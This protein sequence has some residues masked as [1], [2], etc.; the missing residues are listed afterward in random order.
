MRAP[1]FEVPVV[2]GDDFEYFKQRAG[3][4]SERQVLRATIV[5]KASLPVAA[6]EVASVAPP[7]AAPGPAPVEAPAPPKATKRKREPSPP[8]PATPTETPTPVES[9][10]KAK[11]QKNAAKP[12]EARAEVPVTQ[13]STTPQ[14][15][16][17][18]NESLVDAPKRKKSRAEKKQLSAAQAT[19]QSQAPASNPAEAAQA[20]TQ[21]A[22]VAAPKPVEAA[23]TPVEQPLTSTSETASTRGMSPAEAKFK[24][25]AAKKAA[26]RA[27]QNSKR[28]QA[29]AA[30]KDG[31]ASQASTPA[32]SEP[33]ETVTAEPSTQPTSASEGD[34]ASKKSAGG[35][36]KAGPKPKTAGQIA[37]EQYRAEQA[38]LAAEKSSSESAPPATP[39]VV[40]VPS[41]KLATEAE[42]SSKRKA[43]AKAVPEPPKLIAKNA[44]IGAPVVAPSTASSYS[45]DESSSA[46]EAPSAV[47]RPTLTT[48]KPVSPIPQA[49]LMATLP[50][51]D[52]ESYS[53]DDDDED[54]AER[55]NKRVK[56]QRLPSPGSDDGVTLAGPSGQIDEDESDESD[57]EE[58]RVSNAAPAPVLSSGP[59]SS[60]A[61]ESDASS[62]D[63]ESSIEDEPAPE[64]AAPDAI[65]QDQAPSAAE[66]VMDSP[67]S[68]AAVDEAISQTERE[69]IDMDAPQ[70]LTQPEDEPMAAE[71]A[72]EKE[73]ED[74]VAELRAQPAVTVAAPS[75]RKTRAQRA[76]SQ[77]P[78]G[79]E[80]AAAAAPSTKRRPGRPRKADMPAEGESEK[81]AVGVAA[82]QESEVG[83]PLPK[84][85]QRIPPSS[86]AVD[87][88][89]RERSPNQSQLTLEQ[90]PQAPS[91][92]TE[93][94]ELV[95]ASQSPQLAKSAATLPVPTITNGLSSGEEDSAPSTR[96]LKEVSPASGSL[97]EHAQEMRSRSM[98][99]H[100]CLI[101]DEIPGH[102]QKDCPIVIS[103]LSALKRRLRHLESEGKVD[104]TIEKIFS[105]WISRQEKDARDSARR[106]D[107]ELANNPPPPATQIPD[108]QP[109]PAPSSEINGI[110]TPRASSPAAAPPLEGSRAA[111]L[112]RGAPA[113]SQPPASP[114]PR[115][116]TRKQARVSLSQPDYSSNRIPTLSSLDASALRSRQ[117]PSLNRRQSLLATEPK[118]PEAPI[119]ADLDDDST[120]SEADSSSDDEAGPKSALSQIDSA[121]IAGVSSQRAKVPVPKHW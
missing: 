62:S 38:R 14:V 50:D 42:P 65:E 60:A 59:A 31:V 39:P 96:S 83:R 27:E 118:K 119:G 94:E 102:Y 7:V 111:T 3:R 16:A 105:T 41:K 15:P 89:S 23:P 91:S 66:P 92:Q 26:K 88:V 49:A 75:P 57:A 35:R 61:P 95:P 28:K 106:R 77:Q 110:V 22:A 13:D 5:P 58:R 6:V 40:E 86:Q 76:T 17:P 100:R 34:E 46:S 99:R 115:P 107:L 114:S 68:P 112:R 44:S 48:L 2:D 117:T 74:Q 51:S 78:A 18:S 25:K 81:E 85:R 101:C 73:A 10:R 108:S 67:S 64:P 98:S 113:A 24:A 43:A 82:S 55:S 93:P 37:L 11:K 1:A 84:R 4:A 70:S 33:A 103:G 8:A 63:A 45:D 32:P 97:S 52:A 19:G 116:G 121:R 30:S 54:K 87:E 9:S 80:D 29:R 120:E 21:P 71:R 56:F 69:D 72:P 47:P 20:S 36:K 53:E 12:E 79:T 104:D 109:A 90:A